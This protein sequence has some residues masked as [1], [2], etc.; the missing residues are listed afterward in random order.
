MKFIQQNKYFLKDLNLTI[1][2]SD[3]NENQIQSI[4]ESKEESQDNS[5]KIII[6]HR[7][8]MKEVK[9]RFTNSK[10]LEDDIKGYL[11]PKL[12][13]SKHIERLLELMEG[14]YSLLDDYWDSKTGTGRGAVISKR[15]G[16]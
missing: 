16:F 11:N 4:W 13:E 1:K 9:K 7:I 8:D 6:N 10:Y 14:K 12:E 15:F 5:I 2:F 3:V